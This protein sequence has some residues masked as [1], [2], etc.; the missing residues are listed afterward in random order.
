MNIDD[1]NTSSK[2]AKYLREQGR[3]IIP[4]IPGTKVPPNGF[5]LEDY[6][7]KLCDYTIKDTDSIAMLHGAVSN[8]FGIDVDMKNG[9]G[10][11]DAIHVVAKDIEKILSK[12]M[13]VKTPKQG[14]HFIV[15]P[16]GDLPPKN[17]KYF[18]RDYTIEIDIKTQGGYTLLPPSMYD[19]KQ[20]GR[21]QFISTTLQHDPTSWKEFE[22]YIAQKG[23][24]T[25][26]DLNNKN[27]RTDYN[28]EKLL[29]GKFTVG[30]RRKSQN[31][32]YCKLRIR[33]YSEE[34]ATKQVHTV[35]K[36]CAEPLDEKE[37][38]YNI[39]YAEAFFQN[40]I[41]P[42]MNNTQETN[43]VDCTN[44]KL[45]HKDPAKIDVATYILMKNHTFI[46]PRGTEKI[47]LYNGMIYDNYEAEAIIKEETEELITHCN[48]NYTIETINK[49][50]RKTF[51][52]LEDIDSDPN[53]ITIL[54]GILDI[55][56]QKL[57]EHTP[58]NISQVLIPV[59]YVK[60]P[61]PIKEDTI[62]TDIEK[63]LKDT[64]F[65]KYLTRSFT[66]HGK[67]RTENFETILEIMASIL[68][69]KQIDQR[70]FI[71]LGGGENGKSVLLDYI[72]S[73]L[74]R[75]TSNVS[76]I[77][78]HELSDDKFMSAE[79]D[80]AC[81]NIFSDLEENEL[82]HTGKIKGI[83][84][85]EGIKV[86]AKYGQPF[87]LFPFAK[88]LFSCNRFPKVYDQ[89]QGFFR[90]WIIIKWERSFEGD[91]ERV[92]D[93]LA[94]LTS[95]QKEKNL[96][97]S[98]LVPL[99]NKLN[100]LGVFSHTNTWRETQ[101]EWNENADPID[102]FDSE[103]IIDSESHKTKRETYQFYKGIMLEKGETPLGMGQFSKAFEEY[104]DYDRMEIDGNV[105]RRTERVWLNIDFR[106]PQQINLF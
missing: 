6:F 13:V 73:M 32:L 14:C 40:I 22:L 31:S 39:K 17:A 100:R 28:L 105:N 5:K 55:K 97:F 48:N 44:E 79:L 90:R 51:V 56:A 34:D 47:L 1:L 19:Q 54:N 67:F 68:I 87:D 76:H 15:S 65:Y 20:Y 74:G 89:S 103:Y 88:L 71:F 50:K 82:K 62:F 70:A 85:G 8:T 72:E 2:V 92:P 52:S 53:I 96:V 27:L 23:F 26:E 36:K 64:L 30:N 86:Q 25:N 37:I 33:E 80:G 45:S 9:G 16:M 57:S 83:I 12:T 78:L 61:L 7:E 94:K 21:Y 35:N 4:I 99:A 66:I 98:C 77:P 95:N 11:K 104:H 43:Y 63:N 10:W 102:A 60:P 75:G 101:K 93:L 18:N 29:E 24:F 106:E 46:T 58:D 38:T 41:I 59:R 69:K 49:I 84:S 42:S 81:V 91:P 3:N